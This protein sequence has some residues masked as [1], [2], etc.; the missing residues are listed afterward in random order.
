MK[1]ILAD[2]AARLEALNLSRS[3]LVRAPAGSGKTELLTQRALTCLAVVRRPEEVLVLTFT[4]KAVN[5][6]RDRVMDALRLAQSD[7]A[8]A[9]P[10]KQTTYRLARKVLERDRELGWSLIENPT[11]LRV[12]TIDKLNAEITAQLPVLSGFGGVANIDER[13]Q[14]LYRQAVQSLFDELE[15]PSLDADIRQAMEAVLTFGENQQVRLSP[16]LESLLAR[17]DQWL[18]VI[19]HADTF[20]MEHVLRQLTVDRLARADAIVPGDLRKRLSDLLQDVACRTGL[21]WASAVSQWSGNSQASLKV[22]Q[23]VARLFLTKEG[24]FR[25]KLNKSSGF[26]PGEDETA[27]VNAI[28]T[29]FLTNPRTGEIAKQLNELRVLPDSSYPQ[30]LDRFRK[31]VSLI[32]GRLVAHLQVVFEQN[33]VVDFAE[34]AARAILSLGVSG[35]VTEALLKLDNAVAHVLLDEAQDTSASQYRLLSQLTAGWQS[36]DGR[37]IFMVGDAQ[38]SIYSF[39]QAE[40]GLFIDHWE[41]GHFHGIALERITLESNFR[42]DE[43]IVHWFNTAFERLF[44]RE[45]DPYA[46]AVTFSR[47]TPTLRGGAEAGVTMHALTDGDESGE[48]EKIVSIIKSVTSDPNETVAILVRSRSHLHHILP[49]LKVAGVRFSCQDIDPLSSAPAINDLLQLTRAMWHSADR[50]AWIG[51]LRAPFVGLSWMDITALVRGNQTLA[52]PACLCDDDIVL[53]LSEEGRQRVARIRDSLDRVY[54]DARLAYDLP[55][56]VE[57]LWSILGGPACVTESEAEDCA[58][59]IALLREECDG[60]ELR[61]IESLTDAVNG[62]YASP[63]VGAVQIMTLHKAKGLEFDTVILPSLGRTGRRDDQP[64]LRHRSLPGGYILAPH[65]GRYAVEGGAEERLYGYLGRLEHTAQHNEMLRLLYVGVTRAR[66][67]LHL[68]GC[69]SLPAEERPSRPA[70]GSLLAHLWPVVSQEFSALQPVPS[71]NVPVAR[72]STPVSPRLPTTWIAPAHEIGYLPRVDQ[73]ELPSE[74]AIHESRFFDES[75]DGDNAARI[76][77]VLYHSLMERIAYEGVELW[78]PARFNDLRGSLV[79]GCRRLGMP[80]PSVGKAVDRVLDLAIRTLDDQ[81]GR[82]VLG[83]HVNGACELALSGYVEGRWVSAV[84]DRTFVEHDG[85]LW[86]IDYKT[87]AINLAEDY[88]IQDE[89]SRYAPQIRRYASLRRMQTGCT[90]VRGGLY[91]PSIQKLVEVRLA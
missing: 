48:A 86:V 57:T 56:R 69:A 28:L 65:P 38:Q 55:A 31:A 41:K 30:E 2:Q 23:G 71:G 18:G 16:L 83:R 64:L 77:G 51:L 19:H 10:H 90:V 81:T 39:R 59:F 5:E 27:R 45:A 13:P 58:T 89:V 80:E 84:I 70:S 34:V 78:S 24:A 36:G 68:I 79:S 3:V 44:P 1:N 54:A 76:I 43:N 42:S 60:G 74:L 61:S 20:E 21:E 47:S 29:E 8:P 15:D 37:T 17:R 32:L 12:M 35:D 46:S 26:P 88:V 40:V 4:N 52:L 87:T 75:D 66:K 50:G 91:F 67:R 49:A 25:K 22:W 53:R 6:A 62:L 7:T 63:A 33:G 72:I 9:S 82:W 85:T 14:H 11:R 73:A